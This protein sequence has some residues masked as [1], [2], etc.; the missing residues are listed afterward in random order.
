MPVINYLYK[1]STQ[2]KLYCYDNLEIEEL[3]NQLIFTKF[4]KP[5]FSAI[6]FGSDKFN[7]II[8]FVGFNG[9]CFES[10]KIKIDIPI[11]LN[12]NNFI[13][14]GE[15]EIMII[16]N[17]LNGFRLQYLR[18]QED[19]FNYFNYIL[20]NNLFVNTEIENYYNNNVWSECWRKLNLITKFK[21]EGSSIT[22]KLYF[23]LFDK[24]FESPAYKNMPISVTGTL[25]KFQDDRDAYN[26]LFQ[27]NPVKINFYYYKD[28][29]LNA[30]E[31]IDYFLF[32]FDSTQEQLYT[33]S[34]QY[35]N[36]IL[37]NEISKYP[38]LSNLFYRV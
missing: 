3:G 20:T 9:D 26:F 38:F 7:E 22:E 6:N 16:D 13:L 2:N 14:I 29:I 8:D 31:K 12:D 25:G 17:F 5:L 11:T 28:H 35:L 23:K 27:L 24:S 18:T 10:Y 15:N 37:E 21:L 33:S 30:T 32:H 34:P 1:F 36:D 4:N 19:I